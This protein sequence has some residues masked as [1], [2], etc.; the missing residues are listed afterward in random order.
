MA[1]VL[2]ACFVV[3]V[4]TPFCAEVKVLLVLTFCTGRD[5]RVLKNRGLEEVRQQGKTSEQ[6][7]GQ[8]R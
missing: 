3:V 8:V 1:L 5:K 6:R 2:T 7:K 4:V